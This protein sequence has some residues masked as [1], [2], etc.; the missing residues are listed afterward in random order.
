MAGGRKD[1]E[2]KVSSISTKCAWHTVGTK[3]SFDQG[4]HGRYMK[5]EGENGGKE[6]R[7]KERK[8][9][10]RGV[11]K[12]R[13]ERSKGK[14]MRKKARGLHG[15]CKGHSQAPLLQPEYH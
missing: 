3:L 11:E 4:K 6:N 9:A 1:V 12:G 2:G 13:Q 10:G 15:L 14:M 5:M 7:K 8:E